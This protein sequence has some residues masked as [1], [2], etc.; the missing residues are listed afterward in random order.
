MERMILQGEGWRLGWNPAAD[1][2]RGLL[3]NEAWAIELTEAELADF[4]AGVERLAQAVEAIAPELMPEEQLACEVETD[5]VWLGAEGIPITYGL[6]LVLLSSTGG[7]SGDR[8]AE[9]AWPASCTAGLRSAA[10]TIAAQLSLGA[11]LQ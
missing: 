2:F 5:R 10:Q 4:C 11:P 8:G 9:A 7:R 6:R 1:R 3:G